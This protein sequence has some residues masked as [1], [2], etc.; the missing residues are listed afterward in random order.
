MADARAAVRFSPVIVECAQDVKRGTKKRRFDSCPSNKLNIKIS[1]MHPLYNE[2]LALCHAD[3]PISN[4]YLADPAVKTAA[5][6]T[7]AIEMRK[8]LEVATAGYI[9]PERPQGTEYGKDCFWRMFQQKFIWHRAW[10]GTPQQKEYAAEFLRKRREIEQSHGRQW[11]PKPSFR[12]VVTMP[13]VWDGKDEKAG[14]V[15]RTGKE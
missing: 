5:I 11:P 10:H 7:T 3:S 13:P 8:Q 2:L 9:M 1:P 12:P 4:P 6:E 14:R 15:P